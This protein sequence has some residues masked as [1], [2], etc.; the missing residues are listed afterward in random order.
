MDS[1]RRA[2]PRLQAVLGGTFNP[3]HFGHLRS[4]QELTERLPI[5]C[6]RLLPA[7]VPPHRA[8]PQVSADHRA[9]MV[10]LAVGGNDRLLCDR[11]ELRR[12]GPSYTV[13][14]LESLRD[15]FGPD[16]PLAWIVGVDAAAGLADWHRWR[17]LFCLAHL[18]VVARPGTAL[19]KSG[20]A[21]QELQ[22]RACTAAALAREPAGGV[23]CCELTPQPISSTQIR[24]LLQSGGNVS[25]LLPD[26]V[27]A[28]IAQ[29][30]LYNDA[31]RL[32][33]Q[34]AQEQQ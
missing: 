14:T 8:T 25:G 15:E 4:A 18:I 19:P 2:E 6:L 31:T 13:E 22:A 33:A 17:E 32:P 28:Y 11:R 29:H 34:Q 26:T 23:W 1:D 20:S 9:A 10:E 21:A 5:A 12:D 7:R 24:A 3:I 30:G 27:C 16:Q